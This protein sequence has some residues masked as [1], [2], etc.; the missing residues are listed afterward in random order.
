M[1][2]TADT[3]TASPS[4]AIVP[5]VGEHDLS[6][7]ESL[8][9]ALARASIRAPNVIVDLSQCNLIDCTVIRLLLDAQSVV[10]RDEGG[11]GVVLPAEP[12]AVTRIAEVVQLSQRARTYSSVE[13]ALGKLEEGTFRRA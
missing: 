13:E 6:R 2:I 1:D 8:R 11:F 7:Y 10:A 3:R 9:V 12:N 5:L 4:V